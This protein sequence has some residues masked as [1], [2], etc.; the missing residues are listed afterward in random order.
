[1][2]AATLGPQGTCSEEAAEAY[3]GRYA[4]LVSRSLQLFD[5]YEEAIDSVL[6]GGADVAVVAAAYVHYNRL[7]FENIH[8]L[9]VRD[10]MAS[11]PQFVLA[12]REDFAFLPNR[13]HYTVAS[14]RSPSPLLKSVNFEF[15]RKEA[16]SNSA[17]ALMVIGGQCDACVT[18]ITSVDWVNNHS[19]PGHSLRILYRFGTI[20]MIWAV[21]EKGA[22]AD[23]SR[24]IWVS[25]FSQLMPGRGGVA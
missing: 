8:C 19:D 15:T 4:P 10:M 12:V 5:T 1:M 24:S 3:L 25:D 7:S 14:H 18:N 23:R 13:T 9:R 2:R 16:L 6:E 11:Q 22:S 20:D 17:A 21:F